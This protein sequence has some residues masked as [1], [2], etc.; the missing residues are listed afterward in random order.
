MIIIYIKVSKMIEQAEDILMDVEINNNIN[1][2]IVPEISA[3]E[4]LQV[5]HETTEDTELTLEGVVF[6]RQLE[7]KRGF[8]YKSLT[9]YEKL[10]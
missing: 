4:D 7:I 1:N 6:N 10:H 3:N 8:E 5:Q 9:W 2:Y